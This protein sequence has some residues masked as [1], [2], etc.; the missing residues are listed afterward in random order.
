MGAV[1]SKLLIDLDGTMINT[2]HFEAWCNAAYEFSGKRLTQNEYIEHI[3]GR[4]RMEGASR[5]LALTTDDASGVRRKTFSAEELAEYKQREFLRLSPATKLFDDAL[6]LLKRI[7]ESEQSVMF[8]TAS[9]NA[10]QLF[11]VALNCSNVL[12][13]ARVPITRQEPDQTRYELFQQLIG[14]HDPQDFNLIDDSP[15]ATDLACGL[16]LHGWQ[17]RRHHLEPMASHSRASILSSLDQFIL[18]KEIWE[19]SNHE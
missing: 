4:P 12:R 5:L 1:M 18:V 3:A 10:P 6:R 17:I 16:G 19:R 11:E 7:E 13:K 15:Y 2:P 8:Y 9:M 14:G